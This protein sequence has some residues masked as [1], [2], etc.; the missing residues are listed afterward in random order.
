MNDGSYGY[1]CFTGDTE[2]GYQVHDRF[3]SNEIADLL[4]R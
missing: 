3:E 4:S 1:A 2:D